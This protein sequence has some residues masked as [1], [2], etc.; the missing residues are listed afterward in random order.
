MMRW[1][2]GTSMRFR[3]LVIA[4]A[5]GIMIF[6]TLQL[7]NSPVDVFPEFAPPLVEIQTEVPGM[8]SSEVESLVTVQLEDALSSVPGLDTMRSKSIA[9]LSSIVLIFK[10][11]TD[12]LQ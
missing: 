1:I 12:I 2:V 10:S 7:R 5:A 4:L 6:G 3:Y 9:G 11:G 8:A